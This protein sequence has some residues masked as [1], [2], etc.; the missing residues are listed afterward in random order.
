M[1][2]HVATAP[3]SVPV[4]KLL[5][6]PPLPATNE[7]WAMFLD[8]DGSLLEFADRPEQVHVP[9]SLKQLLHQ[10]HHALDGALALVSGRNISDLDSMF[11]IPGWA[12]A[13][14]HGLELQ[15][16]DGSRRAVE[17]D[18]RQ[19]AKLRREAAAL[20]DCLPGVRLEDKGLAVA[21]HTRSAPEHWEAL[22]EGTEALIG[23]LPGFELQPG[24]QV[25]EIKPSGMDKGVAV[26]ELLT[27]PPFTGRTPVYVGDDLT[28]EHAF[29]TVNLEN[30]ISVRVGE[31]EPSLAQF[32]LSTPIQLHAWL[33]RVRAIFEEGVAP[34][35]NRTGGLRTTRES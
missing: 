1:P 16:P 32:T 21:L 4:P 5:P 13:G 31:R 23:S 8:V 6:P 15:R 22:R 26:A 18:P 12:K 11:G 25:I 17:I 29:A 19:Q 3:M 28:D 27:L 14:L 33:S 7:R 35:A 9:D 2:L 34:H 20:A 30:G 10:L 24:N